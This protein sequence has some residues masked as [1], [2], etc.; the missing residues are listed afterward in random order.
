MLEIY[1]KVHKF[2]H[3]TTYFSTH[4]WKFSNNNTTTLWNNLTPNDQKLFYFS[5]KNFDWRDFSEKCVIGL[6]LY[7]FKDDPST[8]PVA[9]KRMAK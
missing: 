1:K 4:M 6:R 9:R 3:V 2:S 7:T 8:I 5:M